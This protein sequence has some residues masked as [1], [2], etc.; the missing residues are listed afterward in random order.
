MSDSLGF[1][2]PPQHFKPC[3]LGEMT[4][5]F[6]SQVF[7]SR[8]WTQSYLP[9]NIVWASEIRCVKHSVMVDAPEIGGDINM[10][11][12]FIIHSYSLE[13]SLVFAFCLSQDPQR[14]ISRQG[15]V[16]KL[17]GDPGRKWEGMVEVRHK[18]KKS[19]KD[20]ISGNVPC[21]IPQCVPLFRICIYPQHRSWAFPSPILT[22]GNH[23]PKGWQPQER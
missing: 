20:A 19:N 17:Q 2:F 1:K 12:L 3:D 21:R 7:S 4:E 8:E 6:Q 23:Q 14:Q 15:F 13:I 10:K 11:H 16:F 9:C 22:L 5:L 18:G